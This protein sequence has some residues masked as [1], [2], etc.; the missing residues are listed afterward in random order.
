MFTVLSNTRNSNLYLIAALAMVIVVLLS[1]AVVPA[2]SAPRSVSV[3]V[4]VNSEASSDYYL[5]HPE[6]GISVAPASEINADFFLRH[7]ELIGSVEVVAIPVTGS[8]EASDYF[9]RHQDLNVAAA[10]AIDMNGD[11]YL[12]HPAGVNTVESID[13]S[14][15]PRPVIMPVKTDLSWPLRPI[16]IPVTSTS[17]LSDYFARYSELRVPAIDRSDYFL[18]H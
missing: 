10:S 9:Q 3:P 15:P 8:A 2:I 16:I 18:R 12:R 14:W 17:E 4:A 6:L 11:F 5:R 13:L 7:R 1:F